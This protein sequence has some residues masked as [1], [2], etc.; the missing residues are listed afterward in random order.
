MEHIMTPNELNQF[1]FIFLGLTFLF[2]LFH[3]SK[4]IFLNQYIIERTHHE[5]FQA[6]TEKTN[7]ISLD[8]PFKLLKF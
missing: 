8:C 7:N 6:R 4:L 5:L 2:A 3:K 1:F